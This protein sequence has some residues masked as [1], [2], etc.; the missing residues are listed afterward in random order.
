VAFSKGRKCGWGGKITV[1]DIVVKGFE[2]LL[3]A[4]VVTLIVSPWIANK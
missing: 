4:V 1:D 3:E 2:A